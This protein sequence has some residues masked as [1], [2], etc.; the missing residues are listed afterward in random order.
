M[1]GTNHLLMY[2]FQ[3]KY[4]TGSATG[5]FQFIKEHGYIPFESCQPYMACSSDSKEQLCQHVDTQC[6]PI[7]I[8]KTC[9]RDL[10]TGTGICHQVRAASA[11]LLL[12]DLIGD[13]C[14]W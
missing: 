3:W 11:S 7:N 2:T 1:S 10:F 6:N 4:S 8:C 14:L 9:T 13:S 5:A 12:Y